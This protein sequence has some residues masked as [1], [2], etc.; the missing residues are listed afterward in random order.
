MEELRN[1]DCGLP[2]YSPVRPE[3]FILYFAPWFRLDDF[4]YFGLLDSF[5]ILEKSI[6]LKVNASNSSVPI[7]LTL[8]KGKMEVSL[9][10]TIRDTY[11]FQKDG[12]KFE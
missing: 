10:Q 12:D 3:V 6:S 7:N 4:K 8:D 2:R 1:I 9:T 11:F 5:T